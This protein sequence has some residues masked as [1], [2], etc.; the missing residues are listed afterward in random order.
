MKF[1]KLLTALLLAAGVVFV[2]GWKQIDSPSE[3]VKKFFAA[4]KKMDFDTI[5][6][7]SYG[8]RKKEARAH[9][10]NMKEMIRGLEQAARHGNEDAKKLLKRYKQGGY[11][12][13]L[14]AGAE[15]GDAEAKKMSDGLKSWNME[16]KG[17]TIDGDYAVV[18]GIVS[19]GPD[20][21]GR[22]KKFYLKKVGGEW[23]MID[24]DEYERERSAR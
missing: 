22:Q 17:E 16:I 15:N 6:K 14:E 2:A 12:A 18:E 13:L 11:I 19:G 20:G 10:A 4:G 1:R 8:K 5:A 3:V 24:D 7:L 9:A 21:E 23:K